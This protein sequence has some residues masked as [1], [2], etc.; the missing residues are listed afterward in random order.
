[1]IEFIN[2]TTNL[3]MTTVFF[4]MILKSV[5]EQGSNFIFNTLISLITSAK[6]I[7]Y[8][9]IRALQISCCQVNNVILFLYFF[10]SRD[11][12]YLSRHIIQVMRVLDIS[13]ALKIRYDVSGLWS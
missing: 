4:Q 3:T 2:L 6:Y 13:E 9:I 1:M 10:L 12:I 7:T 11:N 5:L 8:F